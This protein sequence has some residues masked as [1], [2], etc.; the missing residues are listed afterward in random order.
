MRQGR[1]E[2]I[3]PSVAVVLF[4]CA[5]VSCAGALAQAQDA[6]FSEALAWGPV[7]LEPGYLDSSLSRS[8]LF[9][10]GGGYVV[11]GVLAGNDRP[12]KIGTSANTHTLLYALDVHSGRL[13]GI[14]TVSGSRCEGA[15]IV[16]RYAY[17]AFKDTLRVY[18]LENGF[19][20]LTSIDIE[21]RWIFLGTYL[22]IERDNEP[23]RL[24]DMTT[25]QEVAWP[26]PDDD[27][28]YGVMF[29]DHLIG[30]AFALTGG[31]Q[32]N[33][34][35]YSLRSGAVV[36]RLPH[37]LHPIAWDPE[38][39][40][41]FYTER[42]G[43]VADG[44]LRIYDPVQGTTVGTVVLDSSEAHQVVME[45][46]GR[47]PSRFSLSGSRLRTT[48]P[49]AADPDGQY[50]LVGALATYRITT[51]GRITCQIPSVEALAE[52]EAADADLF[53]NGQRLGRLAEGTCTVAWEADLP[54][55]YHFG[56]RFQCASDKM[57]F[58]LGSGHAYEGGDILFWH[59]MDTGALAN[60]T[61]FP[62]YEIA[63][64]AADPLVLA[65]RRTDIS[66]DEAP[67]AVA[68]YDPA[69]LPRTA[70]ELA[71]TVGTT[72]L[73]ESDAK[74]R[75]SGTGPCANDLSAFQGEHH[76]ASSDV[77]V[78]VKVPALFSD[79]LI[80]T[81]ITLTVSGGRLETDRFTI[82][83]RNTLSGFETVWRLPDEPGDYTLSV[84]IDG[85]A[86]AI[87]I[88]VESF[89]PLYVNPRHCLTDNPYR[90]YLGDFLD[91]PI[92][93]IRVRFELVALD[94]CLSE[95]A[96]DPAG[97]SLE[98][99]DIEY[100]TY[101][102][103]PLDGDVTYRSAFLVITYEVGGRAY[104]RRIDLWEL[105]P[106][107]MDFDRDGVRDELDLSPGVDPAEP[108]WRT[109]FEPGMMR[110]TVDVHAL[111][112]A[113]WVEVWQ[114]VSTV[115][116]P[117]GELVHQY[118]DETEYVRT[119]DM[120]EAN[121]AASIED[122]FGD[123][124]VVSLEPVDPE[125]WMTHDHI[126]ESNTT[127][128]Q[129][130]LLHPT[131]Y[132]LD[133]DLL[134]HAYRADLKNA[135]PM[136]SPPGMTARS[137]RAYRYAVAPLSVDQGREQSL[138][139]QFL[140]HDRTFRFES[141]DDYA[142]PLFVYH[143][144]ASDDWNDDDNLPLYSGVAQSVE[145]DDGLF[146]ARLTIPREE[147]T[148]DL[149]WLLVMPMWVTKSAGGLST[150]PIPGT[151]FRTSGLQ[152]EVRLEDAPAQT[153]TLRWDAIGFDA[154]SEPIPA[155]DDLVARWRDGWVEPNAGVE[156]RSAWRG[157]VEIDCPGDAATGRLYD[158]ST[159]EDRTL[160]GALG[161]ARIFAGPTKSLVQEV[162]LGHHKVDEIGKLP[163]DH[164][165]RSDAYS[166]FGNVL[167]VAKIGTV[168]A[169]DGTTAAV[170]FREGD[171][172]EETLYSIKT[173]L[174]V[175][176]GLVVLSKTQFVASRLGSL[177]T[178]SKIS[179]TLR[180]EKGQA[181]LAAAV[182]AVEIAIQID[183]LMETD[184]V[185]VRNS[186]YEAIA[187]TVFDTGIAVAGSFYP[188]IAAVEAVWMLEILA[189]QYL[190]N[191]DLAR[192]IASSPGRVFTFTLEYLAGIVPSE[193]SDAAY[194]KA[195]ELVMGEVQTYAGRQT[196]VVFIDPGN[197]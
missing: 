179:K 34:V 24:F 197:P 196:P 80:G 148:R 20:W 56:E 149:V 193:F 171:V 107:A 106:P 167:A 128:G 37:S 194:D 85:K 7:V 90:L 12:T 95:P 78:S 91:V 25:A 104:E 97:F 87:D 49:I 172:I 113:G 143:L 22:Y 84:E 162:V 28:I 135:N 192:E 76:Y 82:D 139:M 118:T 38:N 154:L 3:K 48:V 31:T 183:R 173:G 52:P 53:R 124:A 163:E 57:A 132:R 105:G 178:L 71:V 161:T 13:V 45:L 96:P 51:D 1:H 130:D 23:D 43:L 177:T 181:A 140:L 64:L 73:L 136:T 46:R 39:L 195:K 21:S 101:E 184:D 26:L 29:P 166:G 155:A 145:V 156:M 94:V 18:D 58:V 99:G 165:M 36:G 32:S 9:A 66:H 189:F 81:P 50:T 152:R 68:A 44:T 110:S 67:W 137:A 164:W 115:D 11:G 93:A 77:S 102:L 2:M 144:Y 10:C 138:T 54:E 4:L 89:E 75:S 190:S 63:L 176:E 62:G 69:S 186:C 153:L 72:L 111:G 169:T 109:L 142:I 123:Y 112:L 30:D 98:P 117:T 79:L 158:V 141:E 126:T 42:S 83:E 159:V 6:P 35:L 5:L 86:T 187:S 40:L 121:V 127:I 74:S 41:V 157:L 70:P 61:Q 125:A 175:T 119:S 114:F 160:L 116:H 33:P 8:E 134:D 59:D 182:G 108:D 16:G 65:L 122:F 147:A 55:H 168:L 120:T 150:S 185:I 133:Y 92:D 100:F 14:D 103:I 27:A 146:E 174:G 88:A 188:P 19:Q 191:N 17:A 129:G 47:L 180:A 60:Y 170:A 131:Q 15:E 151:A